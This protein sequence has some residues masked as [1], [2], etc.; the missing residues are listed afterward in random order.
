VNPFQGDLSTDPILDQCHLSYALHRRNAVYADT[1]RIAHENY[2]ADFLKLLK[3]A[4][5]S[6]K[7]KKIPSRLTAI[8]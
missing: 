1:L 7:M 5:E 3:D 6:E 4:P 8:A 2:R